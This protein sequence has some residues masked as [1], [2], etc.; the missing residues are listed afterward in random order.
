M[1]VGDRSPADCEFHARCWPPAASATASFFIG[2]QR[3]HLPFAAARS[4]RG[5]PPPRPATWPGA[6]RI[7]RGA[8]SRSLGTLVG[9][10]PLPSQQRGSARPRDLS[11]IAPARRPGGIERRLASLS[12]RTMLK[13]VSRKGLPSGMSAQRPARQTAGPP[14]LMSSI[15][16]VLIDRRLAASPTDSRVVCS[17]CRLS[18]SSSARWCASFQRGAER[19]ARLS[20]EVPLGRECPERCPLPRKTKPGARRSASARR[21]TAGR[22]FL[23]PAASTCVMFRGSSR[24]PCPSGV[25][26]G[27]AMDLVQASPV[28]W[29]RLRRGRCRF[30]GPTAWAPCCICAARVSHS[31]VAVAG[32]GAA[33]PEPGPHRPAPGSSQVGHEAGASGRPAAFW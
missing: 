3:L 14:D 6:P 8:L 26:I 19:H 17:H 32:A 2:Q 31:P 30:S 15:T 5:R 22:H 33:C 9:A 7:G 29:N 27:L 13:T 28:S 16:A 12:G 11:T 10:L 4:H 24:D 21:E 1:Q 20:L 23:D 18:T 25:A